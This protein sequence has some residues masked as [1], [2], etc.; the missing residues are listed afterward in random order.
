MQTL[1]ARAGRAS[2][3][4]HV[5]RLRS[6]RLPT[7]VFM[8]LITA[9]WVFTGGSPA[10]GQDTPTASPDG[11][12]GTDTA[13]PAADNPRGLDALV[14]VRSGDP[15][16]RAVAVQRGGEA[17]VY[18]LLH[19]E[20]DGDEDSDEDT[21]EDEA[22][23]TARQQLAIVTAAPFVRAPEQTLLGLATY[24]A[25]RDPDIA[26]AAMASAATIARTLTFHALQDREVDPTS[27]TPARERF[28]ALAA[29]ES[30]RGDLRGLAAVAAE[31]LGHLQ[32]DP[33]A[34]SE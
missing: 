26:P 14:A 25:G 28:T 22:A 12:G 7:L 1:R 30:V 13:A 31:A 23:P 2:H 4:P 24:A 15:L 5:I 16:E 29:D 33:E 11:E 32:A 17:H 9:V 20:R 18:E 21:D 3:T 6:P 27:L 34:P 8:C 10:S 19:V